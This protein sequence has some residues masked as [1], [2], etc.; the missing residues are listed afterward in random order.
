MYGATL[1]KMMR[2]RHWPKSLWRRMDYLDTIAKETVP[3]DGTSADE[4]TSYQTTV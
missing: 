1:L 3:E 4:V 2:N